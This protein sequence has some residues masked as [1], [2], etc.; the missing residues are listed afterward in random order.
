M[1][2]KVSTTTTTGRGD[3][4]A[5]EHLIIA[6]NPSEEATPLNVVSHLNNIK[7]Y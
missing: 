2:L 4:S 3:L 1:K 5:S 6:E 7:G